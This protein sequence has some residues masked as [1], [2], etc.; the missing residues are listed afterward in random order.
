MTHRSTAAFPSGADLRGLSLFPLLTKVIIF[1]GEITQ[2]HSY[3]PE[4]VSL[5]QLLAKDFHL[6]KQ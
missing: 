3:D 4:F 2:N 1:Q 6:K 5:P